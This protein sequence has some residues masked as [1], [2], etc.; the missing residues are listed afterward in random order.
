MGKKA[1]KKSRALKNNNDSEEID[2]AVIFNLIG[3]AFSKLFGFIGSIFKTLY[4]LFILMV[5]HLYKQAKWYAIALVVSFVI[6]YVVD[7]NTENLYGANLYIE[8]NFNSARQVYENIKDLHQ[9]ASVDRDTMELS[10]RLGI[11]PSEAVT[12]KGIYIEP[13]IDGNTLVKMFSDYKNELDSLAQTTATFEG[14]QKELSYYSFKTHKIGVASTDKFIYKK[15]KKNFVKA[16]RDNPYLDSLQVYSIENLEALSKA[17]DQQN[18]NLDSL[19]KEYLAIRIK[20]SNKEQTTGGGTNFY[21]GN[22]QPNNLIKDESRIVRQQYLLDSLKADIY[23]QKQLSKNVINTVSDF[24][25]TGYDISVWTD[26]KK[27]IF[28]ILAFTGLFVFFLIK[29]L[30]AFLNSQKEFLKIN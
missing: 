15:L 21:M 13:D 22:S 5:I 20:E 4:K 3:N 28:P 14:F 8:T 29:G 30:G 19:K 2:L 25:T 12:L 10:S 17:V 24:T 9:L 11:S 1:S 6:G 16:L 18:K 27:F 7:K 23:M 26:K